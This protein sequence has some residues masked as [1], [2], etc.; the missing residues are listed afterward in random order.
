[1]NERL[2]LAEQWRKSSRSSGQGGN[3]VEL[4]DTGAVRDSKN[5]AGGVLRV[6]VAGLLAD[7]A[8]GRFDR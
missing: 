8:T 1:M 3:C 4:S 5:P 6:D 2:D 7:V